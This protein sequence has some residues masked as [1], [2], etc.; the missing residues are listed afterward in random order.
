MAGGEYFAANL[1]STIVMVPLA[2]QVPNSL[3]QGA[4]GQP[5]TRPVLP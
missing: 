2:L 3:L 1:G 5:A 4:G